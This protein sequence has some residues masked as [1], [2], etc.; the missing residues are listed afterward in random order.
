[1]LLTK[2]D[3]LFQTNGGLNFYAH[4]MSKKGVQLNSSKNQG[5]KNPFY[6]DTNGSMS[7][8]KEANQYLFKDFGNDTYKGDV[9]QF[10]A[11]HYALD[12]QTNFHQIMQ[13][14]SNDLY[15]ID[16]QKLESTVQSPL[17]LSF[18][19]NMEYWYN[20]G[21]KEVI[22]NTLKKYNVKLEGSSLIIT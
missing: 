3:I 11:F 1:M 12:C 20:L 21:D 2:E 4:V 7:I 18:T 22:D 8:F 5:L 6:E 19:D 16:K 17:K 15:L 14:M 13:N 10:A 9:F